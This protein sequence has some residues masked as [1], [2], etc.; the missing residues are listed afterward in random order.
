MDQDIAGGLVSPPGL[1][2]PVES[3]GSHVRGEFV[4]AGGEL[5]LLEALLLGFLGSPVSGE[6]VLDDNVGLRVVDAAGGDEQLRDALPP[7]DFG[8]AAFIVG[9][10]LAVAV[11]VL[12]KPGVLERGRGIGDGHPGG[13]AAHRAAADL[14]LV[15]RPA[16]RGRAGRREAPAAGSGNRG[17]HGSLPIV[18]ETGD[19][20]PGCRAGARQP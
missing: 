2:G 3:A 16:G 20:I 4:G 9:Q 13:A 12:L 17:A 14:G 19:G 15:D 8:R 11:H 10:V 6:L 7:S 18:A 5:L 1:H